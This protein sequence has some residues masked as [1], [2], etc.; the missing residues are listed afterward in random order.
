M[1]I[2]PML[3]SPLTD[4]CRPESGKWVAEE[5]YDGHRL[6][7]HIADQPADLFTGRTIT[8]YSRD[9]LPRKLSKSL[10]EDL[11]KL[12]S[13]TYDGELIVPGFRCHGVKEL[14]NFNALVFVAFDVMI[15]NG[16]DLRDCAYKHRRNILETLFT[17]PN[18]KDQHYVRLSMVHQVRSH[19]EIQVLFKNT[20]MNDGEGL[21]LKDIE[22]PYCT[23]RRTKFFM[24]IKDK[25]TAVLTV[26]GFR[27]GRLGDH[28]VVLLRDDE[29]ITTSVK[30]R[31]DAER[32]KFAGEAALVGPGEPHPAIGRKLRIEFQERTPDRSYREPHWDRWEE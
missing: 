28:A 17:N 13:G 9:G 14:L 1:F 2:S 19:A 27:K 18:L 16:V 31:N 12:P 26:Y 15:F 25:Q 30:T 22:A 29:G 4:W 21:I 7:V 20:L 8:G 3:A 5:K 24:K 6:V 23:G 11:D 10:L 32:A